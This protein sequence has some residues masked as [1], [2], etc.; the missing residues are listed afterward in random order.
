MEN[1]AESKSSDYRE[2]TLGQLSGRRVSLYAL[3]EARGV[4]PGRLSSRI[5][6]FSGAV[7]VWEAE[8]G[9]RW[10]I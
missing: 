6:L 1:S 9:L 10:P 8:D 3:R 2:G 5:S 7:G 4:T